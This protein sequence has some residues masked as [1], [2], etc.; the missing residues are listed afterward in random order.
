MSWHDSARANESAEDRELRE[1]L[2]QLLGI[3]VRNFFGA[4]PTAKMI[5][6]AEDLRREALR[7]RR[8]AR[9]RPIWL[10][11]AAGL[12]F[13][14][15]LGAL[16]SWGYQHKLRAD[17]LAEAVK[18]RDSEIQAMARVS[19]APKAVPQTQLPVT[20]PVV[21]QGAHPAR[22][23]PRPAGSELVLEVRP[24][25]TPSVETQPVKGQAQ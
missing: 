20:V 23:K 7:R 2:S 1:E 8:T 21:A 4:E 9:N 25:Q 13:A 5:A 3:P 10:L 11:L 17:A 24:Y 18:Q 22:L 15:A 19:E 6:L 12:P 14:L 16:G